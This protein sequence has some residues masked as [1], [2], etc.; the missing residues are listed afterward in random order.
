MLVREACSLCRELGGVEEIT[1]AKQGF[2]FKKIF[3]FIRAESWLA[4]R[5]LTPL[6]QANPLS[7][8]LQHPI[9]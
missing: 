6:A 8:P 2:K 7:A 9:S 4:V 5:F 1:E 3:C